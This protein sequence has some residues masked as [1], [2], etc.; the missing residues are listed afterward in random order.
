M[1]KIIGMPELNIEF[2]GLGASAVSRGSKGQAI[3][4]VRDNG[5]VNPVYTF[6]SIEDITTSIEG[7]FTP[8]NISFIKDVLAGTPKEVVVIRINT[9]EEITED[10]M[11]SPKSL[12]SALQLLKTKAEINCWIGVADAEGNDDEEIAMFVKSQNSN[13]KRRYKSIGFQMDSPDSMH[14]VNFTTDK[15]KYSDGDDIISGINYIPKMLGAIAGQSL[16]MS[17]IAKDFADLDFVSEP[18]DKDVAVDNGELFLFNDEGGTIRIGRAVNSLVTTGQGVTDDMRFIMIVE[19][20]DLIYTDIYHTWNNS[21]KGRFKNTLDNQMLLI[22]AINS[23]FSLLAEDYLLDPNYEN[24][25]SVDVQKQK[26]ANVP[27]YGEEVVNSW[28]EDVAMNMTVS[29]NVYLDASIKVPNAM[30]DMDL[31]ISL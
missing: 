16:D 19:V 29:T 8:R 5:A 31:V 14:V 13:G 20:M 17:L 30:E 22:S 4:I 26:L 6:K 23:Y 2:K 11:F 18:A 1:S 3:L 27:I 15:I 21:Y 9:G 28:S 24:G 12:S 7:E 25:C 10:A